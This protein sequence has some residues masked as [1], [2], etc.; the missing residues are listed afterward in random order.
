[1]EKRIDAVFALAV[2]CGFAVCVVVT[3]ML[4]ASAYISTNAIAEGGRNE[5]ILLSYI[6][7]KIRSADTTRAISVGD[8][9][10]I[11]ALFL[12]ETLDNREFVTTIYLYDGTVRELFHEKGSDFLPTDGVAII[13]ASHLHFA[14]ENGFLHISTNIGGFYIAPRSKQ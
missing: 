1:M 10:G 3:I 14:E 11:T 7:T 8:F 2:F 6:R 5:R 4:S 12:E 9:H 13:D